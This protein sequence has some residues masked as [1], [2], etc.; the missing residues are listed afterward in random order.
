MPSI[1]HLILGVF[2]FG[3]VGTGVE[4]ILLEH[5]ED[6]W[7][8]T[9]LVLMGAAVLVLVLYGLMKSPRILRGFQG[10]MLLF[11]VSGCL[12]LW[13]HYKGNVEFEL[14]M[15]PSLGGFKLFWE[16]L[17]GATPALAPGTMIQFGLLG[18]LYTYKHPALLQNR[19][20]TKQ[21]VS[22]GFN[23]PPVNLK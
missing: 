17:K 13:F 14:E 4:L 7:M 16:A 3:L 6:V 2:L 9:P 22:G 11:I 21:Q 8:W 1:H 18:L 19:T 10:V 15:Y 20:Q 5:T 12:G 23:A